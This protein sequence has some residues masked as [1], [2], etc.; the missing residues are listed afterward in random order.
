MSEVYAKVK[1]MTTC[2]TCLV[3][4]P[5]FKNIIHD[6]LRCVKHIIHSYLLSVWYIILDWLWSVIHSIHSYLQSVR[7]SIHDWLQSVKHCILVIY[8][9]SGT[10]FILSRCFHMFWM[11]AKCFDKKHSNNDKH[12]LSLTKMENILLPLMW[13]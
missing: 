10:A 7:N 11:L 4:S 1:G 13:L 5:N 8:S 6:W 9:L 2:R 3:F 12:S